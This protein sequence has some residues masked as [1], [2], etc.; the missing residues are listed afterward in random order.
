[1][2]KHDDI[3]VEDMAVVERM[4]RKFGTGEPA[5][6]RR[7]PGRSHR[8]F[9]CAAVGGPDLMVRLADPARARF[10]LETAVLNRC[11]ETG[12]IKVPEV[13]HAGVETV[14]G[15]A[16]AVMVQ[17]RLAGT[18]LGS[19]AAS[20]GRDGA[21]TAVAVAGEALQ[22]IHRVR[23][24]GFGSLETAMRGSAERLG[25][26]FI[27]TLAPKVD[28]ARRIDSESRA[29]LD[30]AFTLLS[31]H[32]PV[33][34][35]ST[36]GLVHGDFS[37]A[38]VLVDHTGRVTGIIDWEAVKSG[39]PEMDIGWWDCFF[40]APATPTS[41]LITG[42]E[43][44]KPFDPARLAALRHLTVIRVMIGHFSWTLSVDDR[45]GIRTA[46]D[47]LRSELKATHAWRMD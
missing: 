25:E 12:V 7:L 40:D 20:H 6:V 42:Y 5:A 2:T 22:A 16:V 39:P 47:R 37:P 10:E 9:E 11:S 13:R 30:Q 43:R 34:D 36:P 29:L 31:A 1:V 19:Y 18:T 26:W 3:T 21:R 23:T 17:E 35:S 28:R 27:D 33:L 32:R 41:M 45:S 38:N 46:A 24:E 4:W 15:T 14:A 44:I 8:T